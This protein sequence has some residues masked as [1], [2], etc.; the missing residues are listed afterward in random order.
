MTWLGS[1]EGNID[2]TEQTRRGV[3]QL[4]IMRTFVYIGRERGEV[5]SEV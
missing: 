2:T 4:G 5:S 1:N 3:E